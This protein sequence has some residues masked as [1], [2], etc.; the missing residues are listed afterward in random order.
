M[1]RRPTSLLHTPGKEGAGS[2]K[3]LRNIALPQPK[4]RTETLFRKRK[5]FAKKVGP[6]TDL[7]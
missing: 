1:E 4:I 3:T 6:R 2:F 7:R 5:N